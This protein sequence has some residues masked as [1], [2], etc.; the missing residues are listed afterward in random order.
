MGVANSQQSFSRKPEL[1]D[2]IKE[3]LGFGIVKVQEVGISGGLVDL[4][5]LHPG[6]HIEH[7]LVGY[8]A[9][10]RGYVGKNPQVLGSQQ[11]RSIG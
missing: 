5:H 1:P 4:L 7:D 6:R 9:Y 2:E 3:K 8:L 10:L 11:L